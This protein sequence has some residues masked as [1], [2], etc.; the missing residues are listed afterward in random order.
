MNNKLLTLFGS[1]LV[2]LGGCASEPK[3]PIPKDNPPVAAVQENIDAYLDKPVTWGGIILE[4]QTKQNMTEIVILSKQLSD[5]SRPVEQEQSLGRFIAQTKHFLDP[6]LY[7]K[8]KE[9][10]VHGVILKKEKRKIGEYEYT[11]PIVDVTSLHLWPPRNDNPI[12]YDPWYDPWY[13]VV[14]SL[15]LLS[16][17]SL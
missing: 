15:S 3:V 16:V 14:P 17:L 1:L 4:T 9:I 6:A 12:W 5:S 11:Y 2:L 7:A 8:N 10:T 13:A